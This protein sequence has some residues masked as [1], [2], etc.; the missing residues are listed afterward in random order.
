MPEPEALLEHATW[1]RRLAGSLVGDAASADD[2][3]QDTWVAAL[4]HPPSTD[5][6]PRP[7][8]RTVVRNVVRFRWRG[9]RNRAAREHAAAGLADTAAPSSDELLER[10]QLQRLLARL[11]SELDEPF[12]T[13]ILLRFAEG[14]TPAQIAQRLQVPP[15][16]VRWR[17]KEGLDRLRVGLDAAHRGDRRAWIIALT[18][19]A[20]PAAPRGPALF[21]VVASVIG[22]LGALAL[23]TWLVVRP[24]RDRGG[25]AAVPSAAAPLA[26]TGPQRARQVVPP[27]PSSAVLDAIDWYGVGTDRAIRGRVVAD[28]VPVAGALVRLTSD[29]SE[30]GVV[31]A[32][33]LH[34]DAAG[35]FDFGPQ[36]ARPH[37][38]SA[39]AAI[40]PPRLAAI[41]H[42]D[43][44]DPT[45]SG[46]LEL[47]LRSCPATLHGRV[48]DASGTAIPHAR[49]LREGTIGTETDA[50][51]RY[52]LCL[53][54][55]ALEEDTL[56]LVVAADGY[57]TLA[58]Y[59]APAGRV[60]RD[61]V[62]APEATVTGQ[63]TASDGTPVAAMK[64]QLEPDLDD[65]VRPSEQ[66]A[67]LATVT[68]AGGRFRIGGVA[69]G[70]HRISGVARATIA[71]PLDLAVAAGGTRD[72]ALAVIDTGSVRGRVL[73]DGQPVAGVRVERQV[74]HWLVQPGS[75]ADAAFSQA[76]GAF[77]L[78]RVPA[79]VHQLA[80]HPDGLRR[81][82]GVT[83]A[84]GAE[85]EV[86]LDVER[87]AAL[88]GTVRVR[89]V[90][91]PFAMV[92]LVGAGRLGVNADA[93]GG[94]QIVGVPP[95]SYRIYADDGG[96]GARAGEL[97]FELTLALGEERQLDIELSD[98]TR[99]VGVVLDAR[100][101]AVEGVHVRFRGSDPRGGHAMASRCVTRADGTFACGGLRAGVTYAAEVFSGDLAA[102]P[103]RFVDE[104]AAVTVGRDQELIEGVRLVVDPVV[105]SISGRVVDGAGAPV[106]DARISLSGGDRRSPTRQAA[107]AVSDLHGMF[108]ID[109]LPLG[110]HPL[111]VETSDRS[112]EVRRT[113]AAGTSGVTLVVA[114]ASCDAPA[115]HDEPEGLTRPD[116][117][118]VWDRQIALVGWKIPAT[119]R[120]GEPV[121]I[122]LVY[123]ALATIDRPWK[124]FVHIDGP[125]MR[126][127][128]DHDP[129]GGRCPTSSWRAGDLI[130]D[131]FTITIDPKYEA[132]AYQVRV[133]LFSGWHPR[134]RNMPVSEAPD[135]RR[136]AVDRHP[137]SIRL[138][139]LRVE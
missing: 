135:H 130:V 76:D 137:N 120:R 85:T 43:L 78:P 6:D 61:F 119:V 58:A 126:H 47:V 69:A 101:A 112:R 83:I 96:L 27:A 136:G 38:V 99:V 22:V 118:L 14:K 82:A 7:W 36:R 133:G 132:G 116:G 94:Y 52:E 84:A 75:V 17:L 20:G 138:V 79:G 53:P 95:G 18:P 15:G 42:V 50:D 104:P 37:V 123:R 5:R 80:T 55:D 13:T 139:E 90:A 62:L 105:A 4:H 57:G 87:R 86:V 68:D 1:L 127:N 2:A 11:V 103:F 102:H 41:E 114:R 97:P 49:L 72:V 64:I 31:A 110:E 113:I 91:V 35:R 32:R 39:E 93:A 65:T 34:T 63:V 10:H 81:P 121:E 56:R 8:L 77:V 33:D 46:E 71:G 117:A 92:A 125:V 21:A 131:R 98:A 12:R 29:L 51:G 59:P 45:A 122:T 70:R 54:P 26:G 48:I 60:R 28:G 23:V 108:R 16:T 30:S 88:R 44:R 111:V 107:S 129:A 25:G 89:G 9:D 24:E 74:A 134:Y 67:A 100:G 115:V 66:P 19:L 3:A 106:V 124:V 128:A 109:D 73:R 40:A